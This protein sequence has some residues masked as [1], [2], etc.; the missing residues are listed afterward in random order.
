[1]TNVTTLNPAK[2]I[3]FDKISDMQIAQAHWKL[4]IYYNMTIYWQSINSIENYIT[5]LNHLCQGQTAFSTIAAQFE[6]EVKELKHFN[7][8]LRPEHGK[9]VKRGL[10]NGVGYVAKSLFVV[11]DERFA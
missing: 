10:V 2:L 3:Y 5:H 6:H 4:V 9:R 7:D 8:I 11:L 1:M